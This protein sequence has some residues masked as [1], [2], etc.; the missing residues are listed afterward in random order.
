[1]S[2][3]SSIRARVCMDSQWRLGNQHV[4]NKKDYELVETWQ[5]KGTRGK[6]YLNYNSS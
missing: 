1:M 3:F 6:G 4:V 5:V 2:K